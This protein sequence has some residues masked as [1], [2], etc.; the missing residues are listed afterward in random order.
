MGG[1]IPV[2]HISGKTGQNVTLLSELILEETKD[3]KAVFDGTVEG[4]VL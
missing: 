2:V 1:H 3:L 4:T